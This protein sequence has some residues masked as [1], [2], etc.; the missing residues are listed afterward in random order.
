M[1]S[2]GKKKK[3]AIN[4]SDIENANDSFLSSCS[5]I[6]PGRLYFTSKPINSNLQVQDDIHCFVTGDDIEY[7]SFF[8]D[9][10]P[11]NLAIVHRYCEFLNEKLHFSSECKH[12]KLVHCILG[13]PMDKGVRKKAVN[14]AFLVGAFAVV[15]LNRTAREVMTALQKSGPFIKFRDASYL[16]SEAASYMD[17]ADCLK[18]VEKA[19]KLGFFNFDDFNYVEYE[20]YEQVRI[21]HQIISLNTDYDI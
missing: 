21:A 1:I 18:A 3:K 16:P 13:G 6:L 20:H 15:Y 9:F 7:L 4:M 10:G 14:A 11:F 5:E 12:K 2:T 17:L 8:K 19:H